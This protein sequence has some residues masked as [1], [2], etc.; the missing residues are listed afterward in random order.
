MEDVFGLQD[1]NLQSAS[2]VSA[3]LGQAP[4]AA[5]LFLPDDDFTLLWRNDAHARMSQSVGIDVVGKGMFEAFAANET[6]DGDAAR[7]AIQDAVGEILKTSKPVEI[8][9]YRYDLRSP[10]GEFVE[11]HW[12]IRMSPVSEDGTIIA[13]LQL[14]QDVTRQVLDQKFSASLQRSAY[15]TAAVSFFNYDPETDKFERAAAVDEMFGFAPDEA[16]DFAAPF[17]ER[18][19]KDDIQAVYDEVERIFAAPQG[20]IAAFDYRVPQSDGTERFLRIR[21]EVTLDPKDRRPRL[22][23]TFVDL[24]DVETA[25]QQLERELQLRKSVV[26]EANHRIKNSLAIA[27]SML[28]MDR[29]EI[30]RGGGEASKAAIE[31]LDAFESRISAI[32]GA[33]GLMQLSEEKTDVSLRD[34]LDQ[35]V[36][37]MGSTVD[38]D[39]DT[40]KASFEGEDKRINSDLATTL[41]MIVNELVTNG[42]KYGLNKSGDLD[43]SVQTVTSDDQVVIVVKNKIERLTPIDA[44]KSSRLGS[45]LVQQLANDH[46]ATVEATTDDTFYTVKFVLPLV[47]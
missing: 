20:E 11:H 46:N 45:M 35:L 5:L 32:S 6:D 14:G 9:P 17:F 39:P 19:H 23:G 25:R 38:M 16:G 36:S 33:H 42:L 40:I 13:I 47:D 34:L 1:F 30:K 8:G 21:A 28:R 44:I 26:Q 12:H 43:L 37:Q 4:I 2:V 18:V 27:A 29:N 22:V 24:T 3:A 10:S 41:A 7:G 31:A 15:S